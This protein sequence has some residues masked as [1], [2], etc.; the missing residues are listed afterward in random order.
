MKHAKG[1]R[2]WNFPVRLIGLVVHNCEVYCFVCV[3]LS[4]V[5]AVLESRYMTDIVIISRKGESLL[6]KSRN[7]KLKLIDDEVDEV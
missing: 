3:V 7:C 2:T 5:C 4:R 1:Q 6:F